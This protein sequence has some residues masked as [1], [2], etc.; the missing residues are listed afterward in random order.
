MQSRTRWYRLSV[1]EPFEK[2]RSINT[3]T[4]TRM[5]RMVKTT[6]RS[7]VVR[8]FVH[9][10]GVCRTW[11]AL[12]PVDRWNC[13]CRS[14]GKFSFFR[15]TKEITRAARKSIVLRSDYL[16]FN[17]SLDIRDQ[18]AV[19]TNSTYLNETLVSARFYVDGHLCGK[20]ILNSIW[21]SLS[22]LQRT[23]VP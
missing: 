11:R 6:K 17:F 21:N 5:R 15:S 4:D 20:I 14:I 22:S 3:G 13:A 16:F 12:Q 2:L 18:Y 8:A 10:Y 1:A 23:I 19:H 9:F 7:F